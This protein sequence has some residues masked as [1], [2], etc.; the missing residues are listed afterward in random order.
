MRRFVL[1]F[2]ASVFAISAAPSASNAQDVRVR[3]GGDHGYS[4]HYDHGFRGARAE[5][6]GHHDRGWH[7]GWRHHNRIV[8]IKR[9]HHHWH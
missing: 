5:F 4:R 6:Y 8:V 2:A 3:I 1:A 9:R 7:R